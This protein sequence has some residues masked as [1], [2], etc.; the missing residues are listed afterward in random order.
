MKSKS[1]FESSVSWQ[2]KFKIVSLGG[3]PFRHSICDVRQVDD[4]LH[5]VMTG[6]NSAF[7][8]IVHMRFEPI[9]KSKKM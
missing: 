8:E 9:H 2:E 7:S 3:P 5:A 1:A 6:S 4:R